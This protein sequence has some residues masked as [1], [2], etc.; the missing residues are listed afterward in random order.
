MSFNINIKSR[1]DEVREISQELQCSLVM[2]SD[3]PSVPILA[4]KLKDIIERNLAFLID[5]VIK[6]PGHEKTWRNVCD[7]SE[8]LEKLAPETYKAI[9]QT[10]AKII[11]SNSPEKN[12]DRSIQTIGSELDERIDLLKSSHNV[13]EIRN[14]LKSA[15]RL[16]TIF[17]RFFRGVN[18]AGKPLTI[19]QKHRLKVRFDDFKLGLLI[20]KFSNPEVESHEFFPKLEKLAF[21]RI[22][23]LSWTEKF[24]SA[25]IGNIVKFLPFEKE[26]IPIL[27]EAIHFGT[28]QGFIYLAGWINYNKIPL[29]ELPPVLIGSL[30]QLQ[31]F[32][33]HVDFR[34]FDFSKWTEKDI[35][36]FIQNC[37]KIQCLYISTN[38]ISSFPDRIAQLKVLDCRGCAR[39]KSLP[40]QMEKL[41]NLN[42]SNTPIMQLPEGMLSLQVLDCGNT[43][44][45][46]KFPDYLHNLREL[47]C[48]W[49][50]IT[51]LPKVMSN[52]EKLNCSS[53][54]ISELPSGMRLLVELDCHGNHV[55]N[56]LPD[57]LNS[58]RHLDCSQSDISK[59]P[60]ILKKLE[61]MDCSN[62]KLKRLPTDMSSLLE[63]HCRESVLE[64][65]PLGMTSLVKLY[66]FET[67][68]TSLPFDLNSLEELSCSQSKLT[69]L[70]DNLSRLRKLDCNDCNLFSLPSGMVSLIGLY[71]PGFP[72]T[73]L[74]LDMRSLKWL[75]VIKE[76]HERV[77]LKY[78]PFIVDINDYGSFDELDK[79]RH[80][81]VLELHDDDAV[82]NPF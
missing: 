18:S 7:I 73:G 55:L 37:E 31:P 76:D 12:A 60:S 10:A 14:S 69:A 24:P 64:E 5:D 43:L 81:E 2:P 9:R 47:D 1:F 6:N 58:L 27:R 8:R 54:K 26:T 72:A 45:G 61:Y 13:A 78:K 36:E 49:N 38:K 41:L 16:L 56:R 66:C 40:S 19:D 77:P 33:T 65:L 21:K 32:L 74:P 70:P 68:I 46:P 53:T 35:Q 79:D 59:I 57:D 28:R 20:L 80:V 39:I 34:G 75:Y 42:C 22:G 82:M 48:S 15:G 71:F 3:D 30:Q 52:I 44:I 29:C 23:C 67:N 25:L 4:E 50:R 63:L 51:E 62:S 17:F 11:H